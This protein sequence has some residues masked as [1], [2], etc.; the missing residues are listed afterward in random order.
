MGLPAINCISLCTGGAGL[1]MGVELALPSARSVLMV[2]RE[3]Y[4]VARLVAAIEAGFLAPAAIWSDVRTLAGRPWRGLVD[5]LIGGIPCQPHSLAGNR[6][7]SEDE[8]DLWSDTRRLIAQSRPWWV[9]IENVGGMLSSGGAERV[10]RDLQR[11]G[12]AVEGGLYAAEEIGAPHRRERLFIL[13]CA[14]GIWRSAGQSESVAHASNPRLQGRKRGGPSGKWDGAS[15]P[16]PATELRGSHLVDSAFLRRSEGWSEPSVLGGGIPLPAQ[17]VSMALQ[18]QFAATALWYTPNVPNGGR[19]NPET[20]SATGKLDNG[21][22]RQVGLENQ[23]RDGYSHP[24]LGTQKNGP[25]S[26]PS[27]LSLNPLFVESLMG[28]PQ[29]WTSFVC[30]ETELSLWRQHM[31][32]ALWRLDSPRAVP[33]Q[34]SLFR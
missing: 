24:D 25:I 26:S 2:E 6:L 19:V 8:R 18:R 17:A 21:K 9:L 30:S 29:G 22:K 3:A 16:R 32:S 5:G 10:H 11:M 13:G 27:R 33:A 23:V 15:P 14:D 34:L 12:F 4:A 1:D 20:M 28:W 31:R 7:G